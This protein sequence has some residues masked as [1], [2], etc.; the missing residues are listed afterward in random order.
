M[1]K[2]LA[3]PLSAQEVRPAADADGMAEIVNGIETRRPNEIVETE[4]KLAI[5]LKSD[6]NLFTAL[7]FHQIWT[8]AQN[9]PCFKGDC[10]CSCMRKV[11]S[12][13]EAMGR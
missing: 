10:P 13:G 8:G 12:K 7:K 5:F 11:S 2:P 3:E 4:R 6:D 9:S 1:V